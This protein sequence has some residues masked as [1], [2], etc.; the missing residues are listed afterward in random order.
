MSA[1]SRST[2]RGPSHGPPEAH[3]FRGWPAN[4]RHACWYRRNRS[5]MSRH[6]SANICRRSSRGFRGNVQFSGQRSFPT[7]QARPHGIHHRIVI[8]FLEQDFLAVL[9]QS[10]NAEPPSA[11]TLGFGSLLVISMVKTLVFAEAR[12]QPA[13]P[14]QLI[15]SSREIG[16]IAGGHRNG[17][18]R[19]ASRPSQ[20]LRPA[21]YWF[22][23]TSPRF[24]WVSPRD[25]W[26]WILSRAHLGAAGLSALVLCGGVQL[27]VR[28]ERGAPALHQRHHVELHCLIEVGFGFARPHGW[29][30]TD[31]RSAFR[32][33][34]EPFAVRTP[35]GA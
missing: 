3:T 18:H 24:P 2:P 11:N 27:V 15:R 13:D 23:R 8:L 5:R 1:M 33:E 20:S 28:L 9:G 22:L 32:Q 16:V 35:H 7:S 14:K 17:R 30:T 19:S 4:P 34:I 26:W 25:C 21:V 10:Q 12:W 31:S 6:A 29:A